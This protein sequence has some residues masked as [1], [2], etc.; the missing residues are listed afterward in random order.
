MPSIEELDK[1]IA[2]HASW[3]AKLKAVIATGTSSMSIDQ[4]SADNR[5]DFGKWLNGDAPRSGRS[6]DRRAEVVR[7]HAAFHQVAAKVAELAFQGRGKEAEVMLGMM[8]EFGAASSKLTAAM[9]AWK[10]DLG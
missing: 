8:G 9:M 1:A 3:K 2:A 6:A 10:K 5:C 4:I 7:L